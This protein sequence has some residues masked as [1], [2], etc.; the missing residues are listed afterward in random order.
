[1]PIVLNNIEQ[2]VQRA[3]AHY[4][5]TLLKQKRKKGQR[6]AQGGARSGVVGGKQMTGFCELISE[7]VAENGMPK[8]HIHVA[9]T[10]ELPGFYRPTKKWDIVI[11]QE[12][13]LVAAI[14]LKSQAG[15]SF[16]NNFN[17]R[18]EE[19]I[20][21]AADIDIAF[22]KG[23]YGTHAPWLGWVMLLEDH[24]K[25]RKPVKVVSSHFDADPEFH[26]SS[27]ARRYELMLRRLMLE[28]QYTRSA[29]L[30]STRIEGKKGHFV[31]PAKDLCIHDFFASLAGHIGTIMASRS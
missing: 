15:P 18:A 17:N 30:L 10:L 2:R 4:W 8:A 25:S 19:A 1:M 3:V 12:H 31:E 5:K 9:K 7:I 22:K 23:M 20:G 24:P 26:D 14:E 28:R 16:G 6:K 29:L 21:T 13:R 27:Y 11:V